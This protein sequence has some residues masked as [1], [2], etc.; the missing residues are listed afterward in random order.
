V[1]QHSTAQHSTARFGPE[2]G[3]AGYL[4]R[5]FIGFFAYAGLV[6][7]LRNVVN[8][9]FEEYLD[10]QPSALLVLWVS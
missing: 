10:F 6:R 3:R 8:F 2:V 7:G 9:V 1:A 5:L 4:R